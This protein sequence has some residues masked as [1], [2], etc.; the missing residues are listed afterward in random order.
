[1]NKGKTISFKLFYLIY[2][3]ALGTFLP[4]IN[5]YLER[6]RGLSGSQIGLITALSLLLSCAV[7][8]MWGVVGD[9]SKKYSG[10]L[11]FSIGGTLVMIFFYYKAAVYPMIIL[12]AIFLEIIRSGGYP[13]ADTITTNYCHENNSNYGAIRAMGSLGYML[14]S[15]AI[16]LLGDRFGFDGTLFACYAALIALSFPITFF[17]PSSL[18]KGNE[19]DGEKINKKSIKELILNPHYV[20]I[21]IIT[22]LTTVVIDSSMNYGGNHLVLTLG[23]DESLIS[24]MTLLAVLPEILFLTVCI[25]IIHKI[26]FKKYYIIVVACM[27]LRFVIYSF[28][29]N[30]YAFLGI[31]ILSCLGVSIAT[32]GNLTFIRESV[33]AT[34]L[35]TAITIFNA[36]MSIGKAAMGYLFGFI[37]EYGNS[38]MIYMTC[39]VLLAICLL[40][41][42]RTKQFDHI[43]KKLLE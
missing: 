25:K 2:L 34:V 19:D 23:G 40:I 10:L 27:V 24:L 39:T 43:D 38:Y 18:K 33:N 15:I 22:L 21:L 1:M 13:L 3:G 5:V 7:I 12:S 32:V 16:G 41:L 9:R 37:Y 6:S 31:G 4:Y 17:F 26:G 28:V 35:G 14:G 20:F 42:I 36:A 30:A 8:P 11:R 29:G